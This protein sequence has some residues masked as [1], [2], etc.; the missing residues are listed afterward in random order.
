[1]ASSLKEQIA[2]AAFAFRGYNVTNQGRSAE[3]LAHPIYGP[4]VETQLR[5]ASEICSDATCHRVDL[6]ER[7][8]RCEPSAINTFAEDVSTI[9][10]IELAQ[11]RILEE[12]FDIHWCEGRL[13]FGYSLGEV[14]ALIGAGVYEM[15]DILRPPL[16][17]A[18]ECAELGRNVFM[19]VLFS[20]GR[21]L[22]IK[23]VKRLCLEI[24]HEGHGVI[25]IS[26]LLSPNAVLLLGQHETVDRFKSRMRD[27]FPKKVH[28]RKNPNNWPPLHTPILWEKN[29]SDRAAYMMHTMPGGFV[30]PAIPIV[31][32]VTGKADYDDTNSR[33][34]LVDWIDH[35]QRLWDAVC[36]TLAV[37]VE[38]V[39][40][41]GP[42]PNLIPATFKRISDDVSSQLRGRSLNSLGLRA[43]SGIARRPWLTKLLSTRATLLRAPFV[44]HVVLEDWLLEQQID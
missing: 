16:S 34:I 15:H 6:V 2:S 41:V 43:M 25:G 42:E 31:S 29:I 40:H 28:L 35:P 8:R 30:K 24:N 33:E 18:R 14:A 39:V 22:D 26:S 3:L 20:R 32:L 10:A 44:E 12:V 27:Y 21:E 13:A 37:G 7:V 9:I 11:L 17:M 38:T 5:E 1:M 4:I 19:G 36:E 23:L